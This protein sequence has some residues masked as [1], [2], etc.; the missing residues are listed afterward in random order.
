MRDLPREGYRVLDVPL[1]APIRVPCLRPAVDWIVSHEEDTDVESG[2]G[3]DYV[4]H[5]ETALAIPLPLGLDEDPVGE[6]EVRN[7]LVLRLGYGVLDR[8][9]FVRVRYVTLV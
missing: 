3:L 1:L 4:N 9:T 7:V 2:I 6:F 5:L 8:T